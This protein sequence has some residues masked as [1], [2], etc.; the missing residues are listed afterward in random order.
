METWSDGPVIEQRV[1]N[2]GPGGHHQLGRYTCRAVISSLSP[3]P[4]PPTHPPLSGFCLA[5]ALPT[6]P[7]C[8][9]ATDKNKY[10]G[11]L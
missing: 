6:I 8:V 4:P 3:P 7:A 9:A 5:R 10:Y 11:G 2:L 1:I